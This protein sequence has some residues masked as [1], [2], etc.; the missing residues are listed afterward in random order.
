[1]RIAQQHWPPGIYQV[2][3]GIAVDVEKLRACGTFDEASLAADRTKRPDRGIYPAGDQFA[4]AFVKF[5]G[6]A[7]VIRSFG[8]AFIVSLQ[9]L[10][11]DL[12]Q[13]LT[14]LGV[15]VAAGA[16]L[17]DLLRMY[18]SKWQHVNISGPIRHTMQTGK[19]T[20]SNEDTAILWG[21]EYPLSWI[22]RQLISLQRQGF[23]DGF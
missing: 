19:R 21:M 9:Q 11:D 8:H 2:N 22:T 6:S 16:I 4:G 14:L 17:L 7:N 18:C 10:I 5:G 23:N 12:S 15:G 20:K 1:M 3:I 13:P